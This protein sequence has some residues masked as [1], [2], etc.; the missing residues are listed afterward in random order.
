MEQDG[1]EAGLRGEV[2]SV[3]QVTR[4]MSSQASTPN[5]SPLNQNEEGRIGLSIARIGPHRNVPTP[6]CMT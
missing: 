1:F 6:K 5:T 3:A 4:I 2:G